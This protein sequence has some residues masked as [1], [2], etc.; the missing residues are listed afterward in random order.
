MKKFLT[1]L[2]FA[3][4]IFSI[5]DFKPGDCELET[6]TLKNTKSHAVSYAVRSNVTETSI[7]PNAT[8]LEIKNGLTVLYGPKFLSQFFL[9]SATPNG[10]NLLTL[11][12]NEEV[13]LSFSAC[14]D[15]EA[16]N[17]YQKTKV[18]FDLIFGEVITDHIVINEVFYDVDSAHGKD[19][20]KDM[21]LIIS[22]NGE[23]STNIIDVSIFNTCVVVQQN[24]TNVVN[25][26]VAGSSTGGNTGGNI[27]TGNAKVTINLFNYGSINIGGDVCSKKK[28]QNDEWVELYNP[29]NS[30]IN[31]KNWVLEDNSGNLTKINA[32]KTIKSGGFALISKSSSTWSKWSEP[33]SATKIELGGAIG[34]GLDDGGDHLYLKNPQAQIVDS[35]GWEDDTAIWPSNQPFA[36]LGNSIER[37]SPGYDFNLPFDWLESIP[38][39]PGL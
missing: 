16:G 28:G 22:G 23:R 10:L 13:T 36:N 27:S 24:N 21:N 33:A 5:N 38:P 9:D 37:L 26:V 31:L 39:T 12:P 14:F 7:L 19:S 6:Y 35:V 11:Q 4:A 34:D 30:D 25:S 8:I 29:T 32:N 15:I 1:T 3:G 17:E 2:L 20:A 18:I